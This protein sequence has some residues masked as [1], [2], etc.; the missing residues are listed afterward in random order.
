MYKCTIHTASLIFAS[1]DGTLASSISSGEFYDATL[2][3]TNFDGLNDH[4]L[5]EFMVSYCLKFRG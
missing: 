2:P 3:L 4:W 1:D 5:F